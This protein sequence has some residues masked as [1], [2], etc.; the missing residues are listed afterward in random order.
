MTSG[1]G[2]RI[3]GVFKTFHFFLLKMPNLP[4]L[5]DIWFMKSGGCLTFDVWTTPNLYFL[6]N[7]QFT[8]RWRRPKSVEQRRSY[9]YI[10]SK[11]IIFFI[12]Y[13]MEYSENFKCSC[14]GQ[15]I[16]MKFCT[17]T[18]TLSWRRYLSVDLSLYDQ[19]LRQKR[20]NHT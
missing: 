3:Y 19:N 2:C 1:K 13:C 16:G 12:L 8:T 7:V 14:L 18:L 15:Y 10:I 17:L 5:E 20:V 6:E 9:V 11:E 4:C